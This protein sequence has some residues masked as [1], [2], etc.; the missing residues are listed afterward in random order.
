MF[1]YILLLVL[2]IGGF[3]LSKKMNP[4]INVAY[5]WMICTIM[6]LVIAFRGD[7]MGGDTLT[8]RTLFRNPDS[9]D[10]IWFTEPGLIVIN[11][12]FHFFTDNVY[13]ASFFKALFNLAPIFILIKKNSSNLLASIFLFTTFSWEG[14]MF[15]LEFSAERQ[16][17]ALAFFCLFLLFFEKNNYR[18]NIPSVICLLIMA[19]IHHSSLLVILLLLLNY[20]NLNK[21]TY[22]IITIV[23]SLSLYYVG[24]YLAP[25]MQFATAGDRDY[26]F[27]L[28]GMDNGDKSLITLVP[29]VGVFLVS[30]F[31]LPKEKI[32]NIWF[33]GFFIV[34]VLT[35]FMMPMGENISRM[36]AYFYFGAFISIPWT[37]D[38]IK[39][40]LIKYAY[41]AAVFGY[42][43]YRFVNVLHTMSEQLYGMVPYQTFFD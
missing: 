37:F 8:Y 11:K 29:F 5:Y 42:F 28:S 30:L 26:G 21:K 40:K 19:N 15:L 16:C 34:T 23:A 31:Y 9:P 25:M 4:K 2:I 22:L 6:F 12:I 32:N 24:D 20:V 18:Y 43:T 33:K 14:G 17:F 27:Y 13:V 38:Y 36:C 35:A 3:L 7:T 1:I 39:N 10:L 41:L